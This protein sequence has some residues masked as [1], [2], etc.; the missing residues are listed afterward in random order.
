MWQVAAAIAITLHRACVEP[1]TWLTQASPNTSSKERQTNRQEQPLRMRRVAA[2]E[3]RNI[4]GAQRLSK[5]N[6]SVRTF[7]SHR[8]GNDARSCRRT[9]AHGRWL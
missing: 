4:A 8:R 7:A 6:H 9:L 5:L 3:H 1:S 2:A